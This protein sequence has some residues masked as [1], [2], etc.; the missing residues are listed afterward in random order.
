MIDKQVNEVEKRVKGGKKTKKKKKPTILFVRILSRM[1]SKSFVAG[2]PKNA[3][4]RS[5][6]LSL[7]QL[8]S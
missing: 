7:L 1:H 3:N 6:I 2:T 8:L 5:L 4:I